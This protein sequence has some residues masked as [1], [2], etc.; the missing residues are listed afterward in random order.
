MGGQINCLWGVVRVWGAA[1]GT[2]VRTELRPAFQEMFHMS[3]GKKVGGC[4][5]CWGHWEGRVR[6]E[7]STF[8]FL[9]C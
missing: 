8:P 2:E 6:S 3:R 1:P 4:T 7:L 9:R 5:L